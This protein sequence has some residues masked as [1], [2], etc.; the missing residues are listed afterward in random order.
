MRYKITVEVVDKMSFH[1]D[2]EGANGEEKAASCKV[3]SWS[4][5]WPKTN[6]CDPNIAC[7]R[8][9]AM[10]VIE[11]NI[12]PDS[13]RMEIKFTKAE[14][15]VTKAWALGEEEGGDAEPKVP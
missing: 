5:K 4:A 12:I 15:V 14:P 1:L 7:A 10:R 9:T 11:A 13:D 6:K 3:Q 8:C 2:V